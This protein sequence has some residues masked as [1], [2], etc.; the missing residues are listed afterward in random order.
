MRIE[1]INGYN[2]VCGNIFHPN[3][4]EDSSVWMG[5]SGSKVVVTHTRRYGDIVEVYYIQTSD[6]SFR[7]IHKDSFAFQCRYCLVVDVT[8]KQL[9]A[10]LVGKGLTL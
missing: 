8:D 10:N 5:S 7:E 4:I 3:D 1:N 2:I 9:M 6:P